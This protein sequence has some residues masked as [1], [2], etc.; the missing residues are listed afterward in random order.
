MIALSD[1]EYS[2]NTDGLS[3][4]LGEEK[5]ILIVED[6]PSVMALYRYL[7]Q[8][9]GYSVITAEDGEEALETFERESRHIDLLITDICLPQIGAVEMLVRMKSRGLLPRILICSG[10]VE[11]ET[12][13]QLREAGAANFLA[14]P[15]RHGDILSEVER[16]MRL[17]PPDEVRTPDLRGIHVHVR[18]SFTTFPCTSVRRKSRP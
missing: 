1:L 3:G 17:T 2:R 7:F 14:K 12:E 8:R 9:A 11:Y 5:R 16:I 4:K 15:F 10:A 13:L 6:D 18:I